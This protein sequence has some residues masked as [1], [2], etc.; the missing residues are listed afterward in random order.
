MHVLVPVCS[1]LAIPVSFNDS[2]M[3]H[4]SCSF[5]NV[6]FLSSCVYMCGMP[7]HTGIFAN[8]W[9]HMCMRMHKHVEV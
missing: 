5:V 8:V 3:Y 7:V 9:V 2:V 4:K 6:F 1:L